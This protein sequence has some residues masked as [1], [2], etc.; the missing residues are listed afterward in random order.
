MMNE[1]IPVQLQDTGSG[2]LA[3]ADQTQTDSN[4][5]MIHRIGYLTRSLHDNLRQLGVD[6][7]IERVAQDIPD[8]RDRLNY[9]ARMTEQAAEKVL[10][11]TDIATPLQDEIA[12]RANSFEERWKVIL[13]NPSLK[14]EYDQLAQET[15]EFLHKTNKNSK[16]T[17]DL[18]MEIMMA[19]DFQDLTGQ[20]IK[21]IT[22]L[23]QDL[24]KQLVQLLLDFSPAAK[25]DEDGLLNGPHHQQQQQLMNQRLNL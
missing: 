10:N 9:V 25:K 21:K 4:G 20:V 1:T 19:Q 2:V 6:K 22:N 15:L 18:L 24:E 8:A 16:E 3:A 11:A 12:T 5:D 7:M 13:S 14:S 17:K 23:A